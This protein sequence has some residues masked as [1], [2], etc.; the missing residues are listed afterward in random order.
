LCRAVELGVDHI[1]T[2]QYHGPGLL[3]PGT[4]SISQLE[5]NVAAATV[6]LDSEARDLLG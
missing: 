4:S 6:G 3:I 2:A 5:E 1:D